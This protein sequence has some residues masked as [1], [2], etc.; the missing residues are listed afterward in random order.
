M[1]GRGRLSDLLAIPARK[2][3]AYRLGEL[4]RARDYLERLSD[5]FAELGKAGAAACWERTGGGHDDALARQVI[6]NGLRF[7]RL[8]SNAVTDRAFAAAASV[9]SSSSL[10]SA[11]RSSS[12]SSIC[13]RRH[14]LRSALAPYAS[15]FSLA[16]CSLR[17][18]IIA[19]VAL[20]RDRK[21]TR[22]NPR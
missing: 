6:G 21:S 20:S 12:C 22:L 2:L 14:L 16:I 5:V 8:R 4:P 19:S 9:T 18:A 1:K 15:R 10:A 11:S 7:G 3:L 17:W 13:A